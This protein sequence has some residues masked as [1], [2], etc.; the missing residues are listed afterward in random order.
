MGGSAAIY[1]KKSDLLYT[2]PLVYVTGSGR[3]NSP[4]M[5]NRLKIP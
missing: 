4:V 5:V 2:T 1:R 3:V